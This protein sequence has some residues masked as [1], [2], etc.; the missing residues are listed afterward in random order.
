L[1]GLI[2]NPIAAQISRDHRGV[3]AAVNQGLPLQREAN[4]KKLTPV[5]KEIR[6]WVLAKLS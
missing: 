5:A 6:K 4:E 2:Q 3:Q 1:K